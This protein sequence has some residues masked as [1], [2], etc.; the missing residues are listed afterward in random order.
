MPGSRSP[1][2]AAISA[3]SIVLLL[4]ATTLRAQQ[5]TA[6]ILGT[7][8]DTSGAVLPGAR[9]T[10]HNL[11]TGADYTAVSNPS[12]EYIVTLLPVGH[13]SIRVVASGF[14]TLV[15]PEVTLAIGDRLRQDVRL[16]VGALQQSV[17]V[18]ASSPALQT[19]SS[20]LSNLISTNAMENLP[21]NGR[22]FVA[23]AQLTA[24]A[25]EGEATGLPTGTRPDDRRLTSAV[26]VNDQPTSFNNFMI[27][28][29]D[30]NERFIGTVIVKP[31]V[32]AL[33]EMKVQTN[34]YSAEFGRTAGGVI[35]FVTKSGTNDFHGSLFEFFRNQNLDARS[36]FAG[37]KPP[38]HQNQFGGSNGGP[39]KKNRVF[40]F[41]DYEG[42][43]VHQGQTF[44]DSV[45]TVAVRQGNFAGLNRIFDPFTMG[46]NRT[47]FA[48]DQIPASRINPIAQNIINLYPAPQR[49]GLANNYTYQPLKTQNNDTL[50]GRVDYRFSDANT[51]FARYSFNNTNTV[52]PA[53]CPPAP[54]GIN[55]DCDEGRSGTAA[56]RAQSAQLNDVHIFGPDLIMEL[57]AD[58]SRYWIHSLP[59]NYG[60]NVSQQVGLNGVNIDADSSGLSII[61]ISGITTIGDASY[62][63]I[64]TTDNLFQEVADLTYIRGTHSI[65][66]GFDLRRRQTDPFQSPTARGQFS[67]NSNFTNDPSGATAGSGNAV[68]S[69][70]L[71]YPASTTRSK[72]LVYPGLRNWEMGAYVQDDWRATHSL[73]LNLGFRYDYYGPN[74]EVANRISNVDLATG[75]IIIAGQNGVSSSAGVRPDYLDFSPR[76]GFAATVAKKTVLRGGYG[77]SFVPNMIASSMA[78]R[79]PPFVS[80]YTVNATPLTPLNSLSNGLPLPVPTNPANPTGSLSGVSFEGATPY[81]QQYNFTLQRELPANMVATVSYV[82]ALG[83]RQY[84]FNGAVNVDLAPPGPGPILPR[85][86]YYSVFPNVSAIAIAAPW[87]NTNYQALQATLEHRYQNGL[88][89]LATYT[90]AHGLDDEPSIVNNPRTEY[91]NS[92]LDLRH[93]FTLMADYA[94]PF[95]KH[96]S[97]VAA[98]LAKNWGINVVSV[99][100]TGLPFDITNSASRSNSG[101]SDRPN[102]VCDPNSGFRQSI[103]EWFN[104]SCFAAQPLYT[105]GDLGRNVLHAPG[106]EDLD[107]AIHREFIPKERMR[108]QFRAE[109]FNITNTAAFGA[110]GTSFGSSTFGVISS[111]GLGRNIQLALKLLF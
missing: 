72:Y 65:K 37:A 54:N 60:K 47:E 3:L 81:V 49:S 80:L 10:V 23:L 45:P 29:M 4:S 100:S 52:I 90:W 88:T 75:E 109:A 57:K 102:A 64:L 89:L 38:Y 68:A 93:R 79:N 87:Y 92:F 98:M 61:S 96:A 67:F 35:N 111:A 53:G 8:T 101:G 34:L 12:G 6:D 1:I 97:G 83:R 21:L 50:D 62:I 63:P 43:R 15:V 22:N 106:R 78:L 76:F 99:L 110:P 30:D 58:F 86:P 20:S 39:I 28:G 95:A 94:L 17:E 44:V 14:K 24:G 25:A 26:A 16:E 27:D 7:V 42:Y 105:Y 36:F 51:A 9:I 40:Y 74:S 32:D 55:P 56:Q 2:I 77:I 66:F 103:Y 107:L 70:L 19:D 18:T 48:G 82:G 73:T 84:I 71:G 59:V 41:A 5:T 85:T 104:T 13:Y 46:T 31:S 91:G 33:Q 11:D 69:F 108:L